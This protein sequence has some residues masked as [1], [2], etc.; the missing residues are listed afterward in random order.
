MLRERQLHQL[1]RELLHLAG[2]EVQRRRM[3]DVRQ[4]RGG[5]VLRDDAQLVDEQLDLDLYGKQSRV[6]DLDLRELR[7]AGRSLLS[8]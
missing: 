6:L 2:D 7:S 1:D 8:R 5:H 4:P 3:R